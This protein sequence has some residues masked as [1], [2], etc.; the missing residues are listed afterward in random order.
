MSHKTESELNQDAIEFANNF[1]KKVAPSRGK[2]IGNAA[3][4]LAVSAGAI[5]G[6]GKAGEN[7]VDAAKL[8]EQNNEQIYDQA[9]ANQEPVLTPQKGGDGV[10][11][12]GGPEDIDIGTGVSMTP[13]NPV[14]TDNEAQQPFIPGNDGAA[15]IN[16]ER[17]ATNP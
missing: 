9:N 1:N 12:K 15:S 5:F 17:E 16:T 4:A 11:I 2:K 13:D 7:D 10:P 3:L 14:L 8:T 6:I